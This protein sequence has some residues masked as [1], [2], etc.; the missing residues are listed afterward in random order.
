MEG[1][2]CSGLAPP[3][4]RGETAATQG[5]SSIYSC[6]VLLGET[7]P[8]FIS[9][10]PFKS[11]R[12]Y[13]FKQKLSLNH[14]GVRFDQGD[15]YG[16]PQILAQPD[17]REGFPDISLSLQVFLNERKRQ[18]GSFV[19]ISAGTNIHERIDLCRKPRGG[20]E[21]RD[22]IL[23]VRS[24]CFY[25]FFLLLLSIP[26]VFDCETFNRGTSSF[27]SVTKIK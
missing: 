6:A 21:V 12:D 13:S 25:F 19:F 16:L 22:A 2:A 5:N 17:R 8:L 3:L 11:D 18:S 27:I 4:W 7:V 26:E 24:D 10:L 15:G 14:P 20:E 9:T 23:Q 1:A